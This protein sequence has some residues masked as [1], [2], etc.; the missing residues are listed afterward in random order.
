MTTYVYSHSCNLENF[1]MEKILSTDILLFAFLRP[2]GKQNTLSKLW[3]MVSNWWPTRKI[4]KLVTCCRLVS[5]IWKKSN[6]VSLRNYCMR[7]RKVNNIL[8]CSTYKK[9]RTTGQQWYEILFLYDNDND[10]KLLFTYL[11]KKE[12]LNDGNRMSDGC[13]KM[14]CILQSNFQ[15]A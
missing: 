4:Q 13:F 9:Y 10:N 7:P 5:G 1:W 8:K 12:Y 11:K 15:I 2:S 6:Q 14:T 3:K